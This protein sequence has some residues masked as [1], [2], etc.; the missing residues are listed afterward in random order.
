MPEKA[1][2]IDWLLYGA[3]GLTLALIG[4]FPTR[5][6]SIWPARIVIGLTAIAVALALALPNTRKEI[7][8]R[9]WL[10][11]MY[12][13]VG[14]GLIFLGEL[15]KAPDSLFTALYGV[16]FGFS[17]VGFFVSLQIS[18]AAAVDHEKSAP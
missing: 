9:R 10:V 12:L 14:F 7:R 5:N 4:I 3:I 6:I 11:S 15:L 8:R 17:L 18:R 2:K 16:V 13:C 1:Q